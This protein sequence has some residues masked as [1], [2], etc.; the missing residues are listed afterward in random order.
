[1]DTFEAMEVF[2][3]QGDIL[4]LKRELAAVHEQWVTDLFLH[5]EHAD[6]VARDVRNLGGRLREVPATE[7]AYF[8][9]LS[10]GSIDGL[11]DVTEL[12]REIAYRSTDHP[13]R[14][15]ALRALARKGERAA[16]GILADITAV[17]DAQ[18]AAVKGVVGTQAQD[19]RIG[20]V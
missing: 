6:S 3:A 19:P 4:S 18:R 1:M 10:L 2:G 5:P 17:G 12:V 9:L 7:E 11:G 20:I 14:E 13:G 16:V 15:S 8:A